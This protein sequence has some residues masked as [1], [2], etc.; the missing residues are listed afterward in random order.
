MSALCCA[1]RSRCAGFGAEA[2]TFRIMVVC[3]WGGLVR[4][5]VRMCVVERLLCDVSQPEENSSLSRCLSLSF[6]GKQY[7]VRLLN[8]LKG[9]VEF[10][11]HDVFI[12][13]PRCDC[14]L[15]SVNT[16]LIYR[17][18]SKSQWLGQE[19]HFLILQFG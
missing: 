12:V 7:R 3:C 9:G 17:Y 18:I 10:E 15:M 8:H 1:S 5:G 6:L 11:I 19:K 14:F 2:V 13:I 16:N 4:D